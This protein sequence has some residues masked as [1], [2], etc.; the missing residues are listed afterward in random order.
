MRVVEDLAQQEHRALDVLDR[1]AV[2]RLVLQTKPD[3]IVHEATALADGIDLKRFAAT[4]APTNRLR[5]K[6]RTI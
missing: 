4:F 3:A 2:R 1:E 5:T 6:V